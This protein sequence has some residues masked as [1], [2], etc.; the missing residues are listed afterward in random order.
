MTLDAGAG[1][2]P[3]PALVLDLSEAEVMCGD[4]AIGRV[5]RA[6]AAIPPGAVLEVRSPIAEHRFQV[7]AVLE[8]DGGRLV[9][10]ARDGDVHVVR[11]RRQP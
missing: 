6:W 8:R 10:D 7:R 4:P 3:A 9:A 2:V 11:V 1:E 5:R